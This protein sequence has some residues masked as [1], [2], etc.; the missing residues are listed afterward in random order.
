[1]NCLTLSSL[2]AHIIY[3]AGKTNKKDK[4][5]LSGRETIKRKPSQQFESLYS[6]Y[7]MKVKCRKLSTLDDTTF[8][9][10]KSK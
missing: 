10:S 6:L 5:G 2:K 7:E 4:S 3:R 9:G 8:R 1:M